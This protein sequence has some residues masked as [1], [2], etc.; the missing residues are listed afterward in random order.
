MIRRTR[1]A[2]VS[3][4]LPI[5]R[6]FYLLA[7]ILLWLMYWGLVHYLERVDLTVSLNAWWQARLPGMPPLPDIVVFGVELLHP[8]VLRHFIPVITGWVLA[9]L[10]AVSLVR[11][12]YGLPESGIARRFLGRL[13]AETTPGPAV[14]VSSKTLGELRESSELLRVGGP[15]LIVVPVGEVAVTEVNGRFYRILP[16]GKHRIGRFEYIHALLDLRPQ[17]RHLNNVGLVTRDGLEV[18]VNVAITFRIETGGPVATQSNPFPFSEEAVRRAAYAIVNRGEGVVATWLDVPG[19]TAQG[20]LT[21]VVSRFRLDDLLHPQGNRD[22]YLTLNQELA[23]ALREALPES[24]LELITANVGRIELPDAVTAQYIAHWQA[25]LDARIRL[26][27]ADGEARSLAELD[28]ARAEAEVVMIQ[29]ILEGLHNARRAGGTNTMR[30]VIALRMIEALEKMARQSQS[31]QPLPNHLLP[32]L[33]D[34]QRQL[35]AERQITEGQQE[36]D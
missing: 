11:V 21:A 13:V 34:W 30:E 36:R 20:I 33:L 27:Q 6:S 15:G 5:S 12:L 2:P 29:A 18:N 25:D 22:P 19:L 26:M 9:Y 14:K 7:M 24:G 32:Q 10:A 31:V 3:P 8:R 1:P 16:S 28:I 17:E 35:H 4:M 23:R